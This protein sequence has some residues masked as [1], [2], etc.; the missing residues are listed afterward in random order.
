MLVSPLL[1]AITLGQ[2]DNRIAGYWRTLSPAANVSQHWRD[3]K[4]K[5]DKDIVFL[6]NDTKDNRLNKLE[7][8]ASGMNSL[9]NSEETYK[10]AR[11]ALKYKIEIKDQP[12]YKRFLY[13]I[14]ESPGC[15]DPEFMRAGYTAL[16]L[17]KSG[18]DWKDIGAKLLKIFGN[19]VTLKQAVI[20]D[21]LFGVSSE[22]RLIKAKAMSSEIKSS[23]SIEDYYSI[24]SSLDRAL[25]LNY[26]KK[27]YLLN[28]ISTYES[29]K[30]STTHREKLAF[31]ERQ[32]G[33]LNLQL[34]R[35]DYIDK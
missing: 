12:C 25:Y 2:Q 35:K 21:Y 22:T 29:F 27:S 10:A 23:W 26:K 20:Y 28:A 31:I 13:L 18:G 30:K 9:P 7:K 4:T 33:Y 3:Q 1:L 16:N 34:S 14:S 6:S 32:L 19:D 11:Y 8:F 5:V 17:A 15:N 24:V